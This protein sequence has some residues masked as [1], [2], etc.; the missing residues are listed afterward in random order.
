[1]IG[2]SVVTLFA[3]IMRLENRSVSC[4]KDRFTS[5]FN[6]FMQHSILERLDAT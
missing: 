5:E 2:L 3:S 1:V 6:A 4:T